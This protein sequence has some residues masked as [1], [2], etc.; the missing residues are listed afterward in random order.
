MARWSLDGPSAWG[1][2]VWETSKRLEAKTKRQTGR[3]LASR[4]GPVLALGGRIAVV[5]PIGDGLA[6][7]CD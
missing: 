1:K 2:Q 3:T 6:I 7:K 5:E 4:R